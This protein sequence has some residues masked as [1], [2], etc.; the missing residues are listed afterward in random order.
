M[1]LISKLLLSAAL[2]GSA[3]SASAQR[4]YSSS[5]NY[6]NSST[7]SS[8]SSSSG[9]QMDRLI[10]GGG[11]YGGGGTGMISLGVSP[12]VGY[13]FND[14]FAA[15]ISLGYKYYYVKNY[16]PVYNFTFNRNDYKNLNSHIFSPGLWARVNVFKTIFTHFE[17][18]Y[19]ISTY[20]DY[21]TNYDNYSIASK[22][23]TLDVPCLLVGAGLKQPVGE[24][25]S[26]VIYALYDVLQNIES[27]TYRNSLGLKQSRSPY[28]G[29]IDIRIG[30]NIGFR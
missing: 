2:I 12:I 7:S 25:S 18:E 16:I 19:N 24:N 11:L 3:V 26:F 6:A 22:R 29:T 20:K 10:Y 13:Q 14:F 5:G 4:Q 27:N 1:K 15:G 30:M 17:F 9:F 21:Y 8:K 28:A 23:V